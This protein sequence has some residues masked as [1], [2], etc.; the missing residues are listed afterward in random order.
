MI[1]F[2]L[3]FLVGML[4]A[5]IQVQEETFVLDVQQSVEIEFFDTEAGV[6]EQAIIVFDE[7]NSDP[8]YQSNRDAFLC[9]GV[10]LHASHI[11]FTQLETEA[12]EI[13][14]DFS[15]EIADVGLDNWRTLGS[16]VGTPQEGS[17]IPFSDPRFAL[18]ENGINT[19]ADILLSEIPSYRIRFTGKTSEDTS[20]MSVEVSIQSVLSD[21]EA[22]CPAG[23]IAPT[24]DK[25]VTISHGVTVDFE[26]MDNGQAE[27]AAITLGDLRAEPAF[28]AI[29]GEITCAAIDKEASSIQVIDMTGSEENFRLD[30][31]FR[32]KG[33]EEWIS[34]AMY[35]GSLSS[36]LLLNFSASGFAL[37]TQ[38]ASTLATQAASDSPSF[39][40]RIEGTSSTDIEDLEIDVIVGLRFATTT[41]GCSDTP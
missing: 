36:D 20:A 22:S 38:G 19:M 33:T 8:V 26:S 21:G 12:Q 27:A 7:L 24:G 40:L 6:P 5:C 3:L 10:D 13:Y 2:S 17:T 31:Q 4:A 29:H 25:P 28:A 9:A 37:P 23:I 32:Q 14:V 41:D 1:R 15:L 11:D 35:Q 39:E 30:V 16:F 18:D 34:L